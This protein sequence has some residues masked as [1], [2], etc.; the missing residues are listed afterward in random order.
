MPCV[1]LCNVQ[2]FTGAS[3]LDLELTVR[4]GEGGRLE[5]SL[6][7]NLDLFNASTARRMLDHLMVCLCLRTSQLSGVAVA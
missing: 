5:C 4:E 2:V 7:F 6:A 3:T 1:E